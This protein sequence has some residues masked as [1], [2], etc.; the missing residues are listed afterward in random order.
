M[1]AKVCACSAP[2]PPVDPDCVTK[3]GTPYNNEKLEYNFYKNS[4]DDMSFS[5]TRNSNTE[6]FINT[7]DRYRYGYVNYES[8][9]S[10]SI[11]G[12]TDILLEDF[13]EWYH[14][15]VF[16]P[17]FIKIIKEFIKQYK[18]ALIFIKQKLEIIEETKVISFNDIKYYF[19][20]GDDVVVNSKFGNY[21]QGLKIKDI[22]YGESFGF[23]YMLI[24][25]QNIVIHNG[26]LCS[27]TNYYKI[28][29][30]TGNKPIN[31][32]NIHKMTEEDKQ[33][34]KNRS[35]AIEQYL[36]SVEYVEYIGNMYRR[37]WFGINS[38]NS[39]GRIMIDI[40][41]FAKFEPNY[42]I[43][44]D[45]SDNVTFDGPLKYTCPPTIYG[46]SMR[47]KMWGEFII[48]SISPVCFRKDAFDLLV[49][50]EDIK[51][52]TRAL[53]E[54]KIEFTDLISGK[55]GGM[56]FLLHGDP[57]VGKTLTAE[58]I[59]EILERPLYMVTVG[60]LGTDVETLENTLRDVLELSTLWNAVL[61]I[62]EADIFLEART[63]RDIERNAMVGIF[64]RLLEYY[65]GVLFLT[66]NR[67]NC[68][69]KA[70]I[71][72]ISLML[73]YDDLSRESRKQIW[74]T[75]IEA[76]GIQFNDNT[77]LALSKYDINGRQIKNIIRMSML[78]AK[79]QHTMVSMNH[80][81]KIIGISLNQ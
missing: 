63:E 21:K 65:S 49:M 59:S 26:K 58:A 47:L 51:Q 37:S 57:G 76:Q 10:F 31:E 30:Y 4:S 75:L 17:E 38:F 32:L 46:Y 40:S 61:L 13:T 77:Y 36:N 20:V 50:D 6:K 8:V 81:E 67:V 64:L 79:S 22:D 44:C 53:V 14:T 69:D 25:C 55:G 62:D 24:I 2:K 52:I 12:T 74:K 42:P 1:N 54:T 23:S 48:D 60:E 7:L 80:I 16:E 71:S 78:L 56:I 15:V 28:P 43:Y 3:K 72:R 70:F 19:N 73:K 41:S 68:I 27:E 11:D 45:N 18:K 66:T 5:I 9:L 29:D 34:F 33:E 35:I 39:N